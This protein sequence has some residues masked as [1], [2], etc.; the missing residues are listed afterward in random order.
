L[1]L[2]SLAA[3]EQQESVGDFAADEI[4]QLLAQGERSIVKEGTTPAS[5]VFREL[6]QR[7]ARRAKSHACDGKS[8]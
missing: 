1:V 6:R 5:D 3:L 2:A 8:S 4:N 7:G